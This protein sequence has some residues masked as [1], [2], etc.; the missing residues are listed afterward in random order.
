MSYSQKN[1]TLQKNPVLHPFRVGCFVFMATLGCFVDSLRPISGIISNPRRKHA[2]PAKLIWKPN[3]Q[4]LAKD[5]SFKHF[6]NSSNNFGDLSIFN[7]SKLE[8]MGKKYPTSFCITFDLFFLFEKSME[9][10]STKCQVDG[11]TMVYSE[12]CFGKNFFLNLATSGFQDQPQWTLYCKKCIPA[13]PYWYE[14]SGS[15]S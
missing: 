14:M 12:S 4:R 11:Q 6:S 10:R 9:S 7:P 1:K 15:N 13:Q 3:K 8:D 5:N 2:H